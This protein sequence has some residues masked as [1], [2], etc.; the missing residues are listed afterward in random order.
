MMEAMRS[1]ET[2]AEP[3]GVTSEKT[4]FFIVIAFETSDLTMLVYSRIIL[5]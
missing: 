3:H 5:S 4:P 1:S 2:L